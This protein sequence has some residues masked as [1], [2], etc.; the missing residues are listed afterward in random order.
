MDL[1]LD[2]VWLLSHFHIIPL[3]S[4]HLALQVSGE[5]TVITLIAHPSAHCHQHELLTLIEEVEG[6][7]LA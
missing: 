2:P 6:S 4:S 7:L 1:S 3:H 5:D